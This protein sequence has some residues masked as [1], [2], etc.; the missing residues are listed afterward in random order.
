MSARAHLNLQLTAS[1]SGTSPV[2][3][4][5]SATTA[6]L[7]LFTDGTADNQIKLVHKSE[8]TITGSGNS[9]I[10]LTSLEDVLG[11]AMSGLDDVAVVI[12]ESDPDNGDALSIKPSASNGW[13][14]LLADASDILTLQPG[15]RVALFSPV[16]GS[17]AVSGTNKSINV[18][19][20]DASAA[21]LTIT[22][23]GRTA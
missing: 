3:G 9:D 15:A 10:D 21:T 13:T 8:Q 1:M 18:A 17:Y 23:L 7:Q 5:L 12:F 16:D 6:Y 14:A 11:D 4:Q 20:A 2:G 19:N 22:L